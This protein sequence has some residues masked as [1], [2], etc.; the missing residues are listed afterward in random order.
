MKC[1]ACGAF[2]R[3]YTSIRSAAIALCLYWLGNTLSEWHLVEATP[4]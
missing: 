4:P 2:D 3:G 1:I